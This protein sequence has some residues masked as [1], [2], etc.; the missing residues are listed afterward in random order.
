MSLFSQCLSL[1]RKGGCMLIFRLE[2]QSLDFILITV[3][4]YHANRYLLPRA[5]HPPET[6]PKPRYPANSKIQ[7]TQAPCWE[8][9]WFVL[10]GKHDDCLEKHG[11]RRGVWG[12]SPQ[13]RKVF[14][15]YGYLYS[16]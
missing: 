1:R 4:R 10:L 5:M 11:D 12:H 7:T 14:G 6:V 9:F 2:F 15:P 8:G 13:V 3:H 16:S